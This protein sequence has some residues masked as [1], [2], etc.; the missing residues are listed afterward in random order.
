[1]SELFEKRDR[2]EPVW[3]VIPQFFKYPFKADVLPMLVFMALGSLFML[4]PVLGIVAWLLLWAML[5]KVSYEILSSTASGHMDGPPAVTQMA[6]G[7]MFKHIALL[8]LMVVGYVLVGGFIGSPLAVLLLGLFVLLAL[9]AAIMTL[10]MTQS[11]L[12][13]LNPVTWIMIMRIT[14]GA[15]VLTSVFLLLMLISRT[16]VEGLLLPLVGNSMALFNVVSWAIT[17]YFMA[18]SFHLMGYLL[19]QHHDEL[20]IEPTVTPGGN[21]S[22][23]EHPLIAQASE[24]VR[25]GRPE[26]ATKLLQ[27]EIERRGAEPK[28]HEFYRKLLHNRGENERLA[29]HGA[30]YIP[31][32][33]H[34]HENVDRAM[35]VAEESLAAGRDFQLRQPGDLLPLVRRAFERGRHWLVLKLSSGFGKRHPK[36]PD[37]PELYFL[38]AQS[39]VETDGD[40]DKAVSTVRQLIKRFPDHPLAEDMHRFERSFATG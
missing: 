30:I 29:E 31:V 15:Y 19:Y 2:I 24:L 37:L 8:L 39:L 40:S 9:P 1:M 21:D 26:E 4:I 14:G 34:A 13:A 35:E 6:D 33:I 28:V 23:D 38:A 27:E 10:A 17:G 36:H 32:L 12:A 5:F 7:I 18:A 11:L 25:D 16:W 20:G 3:N 22:E